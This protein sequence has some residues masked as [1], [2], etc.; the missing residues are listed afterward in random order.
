[1]IRLLIVNQSPLVGDSFRAAIERDGDIFVV[2]CATTLEEAEWSLPAGNVVLV[3]T[4]GGH[5]KALAF[6][7]AVQK[8]HPEVKTLVIGLENLPELILRYIEAGAIGYVLRDD[9]VAELLQKIRAAH[10]DEA[11]VSPT[12]AARLMS[13]LAALVR[14]APAALLLS[15]PQFHL[16]EELTGREKEV[17]ALIGSGQTNR[18][19][20]EQLVI[21]CGT[22]K[23]HVHN[24]LKKLETNSRNEA[25]L[26][27][28]VYQT[29]AAAGI[30]A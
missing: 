22:V 18:Q 20:A 4:A 2:G 29:G 27:Y 6:V 25:A 24:I 14:G 21:E 28:R 16:L 3:N 8:S 11:I 23:N 26:V 5:E 10:N 12:I 9:S 7:A 30:M 17:L 19:I 15:N 13:H 1:M